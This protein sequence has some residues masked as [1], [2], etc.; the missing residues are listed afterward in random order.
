MKKQQ[1][2]WAIL[3]YNSKILKNDAFLVSNMFGAWQILNRKDFGQLETQNLAPLSPLYR[4]L[5]E[6]GII[7]DE[8]RL[9]ALLDD[10]RKMNA[11][12]YNDVS[13]HIAVVTTRCNLS[14]QYCQTHARLPQDMGYDVASRILKYVFDTKNPYANIEFQG[15]E[16]LLNW[17]IVS[18]MAK[19]A[20]K[21]NAGNKN[22]TLG[23]VTNGILL[24]DKKIDFLC[25]NSVDICFSLD[26]PAHIHDQ[27]RR[28]KVSS[29]HAAVRKAIVNTKKAY[30]KLGVRRDINM[31][32][33]I[34]KESLKYPRE[35]IDEYVSLGA[36]R[37]ALRP[38]SCLGNAQVQW[39]KIG[40]T[41]EEF[42]AF[43]KEAMDYIL[44][45]NKK[46]RLFKERLTSVILTKLFKKE[47]PGYVDLMSPCGAGRSVLAY[48]P[49]GD[50]YPC[51]EAR[52]I[53]EDMF[54]MGNV[55]KQDYAEVMK[56]NVTFCL[57]ESSLMDLW[58]YGSAFLPWMGTCP[59]I[60]YK[61]GGSL[62][63]KM[64]ATSQHKNFSFQMAYL[65]DKML[66]D[67]GAKD[68][69]KSWV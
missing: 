9:K 31:L 37:I 8:S 19:T 64:T 22:L 58:S 62:V 39:D 66:T 1:K 54:R 3:P 5:L 16:P 27:N 23:L 47:N 45:L 61:T 18:F 49:N 26:G 12:L 13:L 30:R 67:A 57:C 51:D 7:A 33:T 4:S 21:I 17:K 36:D 32:C 59:V 44:E 25:K 20:R 46:G 52:M 68:I 29:A 41:P 6:S 65:F 60:N 11:H 48:M 63:P 15:G 50:I 56:S 69:F 2:N 14:C 38:L 40:Y 34:T 24:D 10:Y 28:G 55:C 53:H 43:W 35:I 42:N